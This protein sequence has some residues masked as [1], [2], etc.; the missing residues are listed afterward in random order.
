MKS[1]PLEK[2]FGVFSCPC[3]PLFSSEMEGGNVCEQQGLVLWHY[4]SWCDGVESMPWWHGL[5]RRK[6]SCAGSNVKLKQFVVYPFR[7]L[8]I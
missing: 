6:S 1:F 4:L 3:Y 7:A 5:Q 2:A 8:E